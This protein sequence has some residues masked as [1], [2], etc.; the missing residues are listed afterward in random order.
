MTRRV[1]A[2]LVALVTWGALALGSAGTAV[3]A[4]AGPPGE[5]FTYDGLTYSWTAPDYSDL[6]VMATPGRADRLPVGVQLTQPPAVTTN[7][8]LPAVTP[9]RRLPT[10]TTHHVS[11][12]LLLS[13]PGCTG[14]P[15][16]YFGADFFPAC[17]AHDLCYSPGSTLDRL[18]CDRRLY[19]DLMAACLATF[20]RT[21]P[22][23]YGCLVQARIYYI[24]VR[25]LGRGNYNGSGSPA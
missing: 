1:V 20:G 23:R 24:G 3:A 15:D 12:R 10:V 18:T 7:R 8:Q 9:N 6:V 21:N 25:L 16:S 17:A 13:T 19:H 2:L 14:V 11:S 4:T 5:Q 22:L